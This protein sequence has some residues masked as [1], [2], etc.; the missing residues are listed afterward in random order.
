M[1]IT[2]RIS[3]F[4]DLGQLFLYA[5]N[6]QLN[7]QIDNS[8]FEAIKDTLLA[9][10][11]WAEIKNPWFTQDNLQLCLA[12]W[13]ET[14][15]RENLE[16]WSKD[17]IPP[18]NPKNIGIIMAGN[19][20]LVGFHDLL[21]VLISG[22]NAL[23]KTSSKDDVLVEF[24]IDFL[25]NSSED[26]N[27]AIQKVDRLKN[28]EAVIATGSNNTARYFEYYFKDIPHIIRK[29]R[30]SVAV[31]KGNESPEDLKN[32]SK[33]IFQ[34]FGLGCRNVTHLYLPEGFDTD[35][36]FEAFFDWGHIINHNKY[37]NN[38]EYNRAIYLMS[39]EKFLDNNFVILK[40]TESLH[41]PIGVV[42]YSYYSDLEQAKKSIEENFEN[43]QCVVD[44]GEFG[45]ENSVSFGETQQPRLTDYADGVDVLEFLSKL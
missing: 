43:I 40:E 2:K 9:Q 1:S 29:N 20:P 41:S 27:Q 5:T 34:Y 37:A 14:L 15:T 44:N 45:F 38:Y 16:N 22:H 17:L 11:E 6:R 8:K 3:A 26:L 4:Y 18:K 12:Q 36:L 13:G 24:V 35:L 30:T 32:L 28:H 25:K 23:V 10:L 7:K 33:D 42:Y 21:S 19:I 31:L 39:E